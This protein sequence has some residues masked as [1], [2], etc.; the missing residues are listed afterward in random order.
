MRMTTIEDVEKSNYDEEVVLKHFL[1]LTRDLEGIGGGPPSMICVDLFMDL[2][3][4][5]K[6]KK[7]A[8]EQALKQLKQFTPIE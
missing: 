7:E 2:V 3:K 4:E 1:Y 8:F 5:E 6:S